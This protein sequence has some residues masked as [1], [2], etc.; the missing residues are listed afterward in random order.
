ME[1]GCSLPFLGLSLLL[2]KKQ[3][4]VSFSPA[5]ICLPSFLPL[6]AA[7]ER[8]DNRAG[9]R[10]DSCSAPAEFAALAQW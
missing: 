2:K 4:E 5:M 7:E 9:T 8:E 6:P 10:F 3:K 1:S